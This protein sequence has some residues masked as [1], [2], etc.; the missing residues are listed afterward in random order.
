MLQANFKKGL[1]LQ[2]AQNKIRQSTWR[3][4]LLMV[5]IA[6]LYISTAAIS[7]HFCKILLG[8]VAGVLASMIDTFIIESPFLLLSGTCLP[9]QPIEAGLG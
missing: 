6:F 7:V 5:V 9:L 1:Q 8:R 2:V 3:M 4:R